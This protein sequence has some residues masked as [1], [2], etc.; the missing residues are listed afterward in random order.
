[1]MIGLAKIKNNEN[2]SDSDH[3]DSEIE[4]STI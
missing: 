1:M 2:S 4:L 3:Y